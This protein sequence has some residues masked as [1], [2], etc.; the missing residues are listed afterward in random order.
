MGVLL[1]PVGARRRRR[2]L[3]VLSGAA[4]VLA[5]LVL[6]A[7]PASAHSANIS[8]NC[9]H[10]TVNLTGFPAQGTNVHI[11]VQ[12]GNV[13]TTSKDVNVGDQDMTVTVPIASLTSQL[14][15]ETANVVVDVTWDY[16]GTPQHEQQSVP[17]TCGTKTST[18]VGGATSTLA[19][20]TST[21]AATVTTLGSTTTSATGNTNESSSSTSMVI[22]GSTPTSP[23]ASTQ[24][25]GES[26]SALPFTG[27]LALPLTVVG[28]ALIVAGALF[29]ATPK[30]RS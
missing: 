13:G 12:V 16:F 22:P 25:K 10:V 20:S 6:L 14:K 11:A 4:L 27:G 3:A 8:A 1:P 28:F 9:D 29:A 24:V 17:V 15:G 5:G 18:S 23:G 21:S 19:P 7:M 2:A 26:V 30:R